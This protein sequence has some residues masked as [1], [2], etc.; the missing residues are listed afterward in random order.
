MDM[1]EDDLSSG[2]NG[3]AV[4]LVSEREPNPRHQ[5]TRW[6]AARGCIHSRRRKR[7]P[8]LSVWQ[9]IGPV[10]N[11]AASPV[12]LQLL[13]WVENADDYIAAASIV[14]GAAGDGVVNSVI[15]AGKPFICLPQ[16]RP[17]GEA[18]CPRPPP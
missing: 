12:N 7:H 4:G 17:Y 10:S 8:R 9:A 2:N 1:R 14:I 13:G 5:W 16:D 15:A 18:G 11:P 6:G 3:S